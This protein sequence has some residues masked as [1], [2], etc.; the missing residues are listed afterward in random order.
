MLNHDCQ[1][2]NA[3]FKHEQPL[4]KSGEN[5]LDNMKRARETYH[6]KHKGS[7]FPH[8][9]AWGV[10]QKHKKWDEPEAV[11]LTGDVPRQT[12]E[13]LFGHDTQPRSMGKK[14]SSKK[15]KSKTTTSTRGRLPVE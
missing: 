12:N 13:S 5:E 6:N 15:A 10:L 2:F 4:E 1:K 3:I 14:R 11:D 7:P 9:E 8:K